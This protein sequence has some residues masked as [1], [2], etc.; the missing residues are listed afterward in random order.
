MLFVPSSANNG[1]KATC[2]TPTAGNW[3]RYD[4]S[5]CFVVQNALD[6]VDREFL[7]KV[8]LRFGELQ[9][10]VQSAHHI[11]WRHEG[12]LRDVL[13]GTSTA[14]KM[15]TLAVSSGL[16]FRVYGTLFLVRL[17]KNIDIM[18]DLIRIKQ[19]RMDCTRNPKEM[20]ACHIH[21]ESF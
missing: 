9:Q 3:V 18:D 7:W 15:C 1:G 5:V 2:G 19:I 8:P 10:M 20:P 13:C 14:A 11:R 6:S 12:M 21:G 17:C 4:L 16:K